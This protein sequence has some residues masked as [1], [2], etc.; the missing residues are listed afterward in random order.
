MN[1]KWL[2]LAIMPVFLAVFFSCSKDKSTEPNNPTVPVLTTVAVTG[3]TDTSAVC[4]GTI[5]SDGG[6]AVN[7]RGVCWSTNP[8]PTY[9]DSKTFDGTG[10]GAFTSSIAGLT[11]MTRY[12][13]RAYAMND[14]GLGYGSVDSFITT[15]SMGTVT[16]IDGNTYRTVKIGNQWWMAENLQ[17]THYRD[18]DSIPNVIDS[19]EW[20][21]LLT[22]AYCNYNNDTALVA[23]YGRLYNWHAIGDSSNIAPAG[24][25]VPSDSE[26]MQ[27]EMYL[28]FNQAQADSIGWRGTN[29]GGKLKEAGTAHW[30]SPNLGAT[31][32]SGF[33]AL[34]AGYRDYDGR[35]FR[36]L[37]WN[38]YWW[39]SSEYASIGAWYRCLGNSNSNICR[40]NDTKL[41]GFSIR[42]V[43]D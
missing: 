38:S 18:G 31:N 24:W 34:P 25:H 9:S 12:Y 39:T 4:G 28:G 5:T 19:I 15:D 21:S 37:N 43:K 36:V 1:R 16:D 6:A 35:N 22:G 3:I 8:T 29:E 14:A 41:F 42:C 2:L 17:V 13:I 26:W 27:L 40:Y 7:F 10:T 32:E 30:Y 20:A 11:A 23:T 33:A